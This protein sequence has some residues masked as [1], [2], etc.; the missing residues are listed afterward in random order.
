MISKRSPRWTIKKKMK[1]IALV[2]LW[3][4]IKKIA[5]KTQKIRHCD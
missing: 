5:K 2:A 1:K 4:I 3:W